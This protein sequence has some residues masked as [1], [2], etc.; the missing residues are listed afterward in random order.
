VIRSRTIASGV[1]FFAVVTVSL[2]IGLMF[3]ASHLDR[4][5]K[6]TAWEASRLDALVEW[7]PGL[8]KVFTRYPDSFARFPSPDAARGLFSRR[9]GIEGGS[10]AIAAAATVLFFIPNVIAWIVIELA[11]G[12]TFAIGTLLFQ[13]GVEPWFHWSERKPSVF[14]RTKDQR[15]YFGQFRQ[16]S[17]KRS[18]EMDTLTI[19]SP[20]RYCYEDRLETIAEG[21]MPFAEFGGSLEIAR[22]EVAEIHETTK[23][24]FA[25]HVYNRYVAIRI[26]FLRQSL[27]DT[28]AGERLTLDEM[29]IRR[30]GG[31]HFI[32]DDF[33]LALQELVGADVIGEFD[34]T[35]GASVYAFPS[36]RDRGP[37][38][39]SSHSMPVDPQPSM[40]A[41]QPPTNPLGTPR[42]PPP[43]GDKA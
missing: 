21:R 43:G 30:G 33:Y 27:L 34:G 6:R 26:L 29:W 31:D 15:L 42:E 3:G 35:A 41:L 13:E 12:I 11:Y 7:L 17:K 2:A 37:Q 22:E 24:H 8:K 20:W 16:Y 5:R 23:E 40:I 10:S 1:Y 4:L 9:S 39:A 14:V 28:F 25:L 32:K 36:R 18:G 38:P 19:D